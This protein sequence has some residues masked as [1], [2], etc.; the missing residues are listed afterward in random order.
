[1][2]ALLTLSFLGA[3]ATGCY[4]EGSVGTGYSYGYAS[5]APGLVEVSPG[6]QVIAD[7]DYPVFYSDNYYWRYDN[8]LWYRSG[9][10]NGG[11]VASYNVPYGVRTIDR[12]YNYAHYRGNWNGGNRGYANGGYNR[13]YNGGYRPAVQDHRGGGYQPSYRPGPSAQP[14]SVAPSRGPVVR[15]HRR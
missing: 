10:Y 8:G 2:K 13:G 11:W 12:P 15:D 7:Y 9:A 3:L 5:A 1:M 6:V 4:S 14:R